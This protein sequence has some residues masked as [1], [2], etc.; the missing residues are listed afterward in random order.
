[1]SPSCEPADG[2][3][4]SLSIG[5]IAGVLPLWC[6]ARPVLTSER[7]ALVERLARLNGHPAHGATLAEQY[8]AAW[9][10]RKLVC[11]DACDQS[12][13]P[14]P[15][16]PASLKQLDPRLVGALFARVSGLD[17]PEGA[18]Q[19][20]RERATRLMTGIWLERFHPEWAQRDCGVCQQYIMDDLTGRPVQHGGEFVPRPAQSPPPCRRSPGGCPKGTPERPL[21][22]TATD[23]QVWLHDLECRTTG[24][25]PCD[26]VVIRNA[27]WIQAAESQPGG[28]PTI[29]E[30]S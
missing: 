14:R 9:L 23:R 27:V 8:A 10:C 30:E 13:Q 17:D 15:L 18:R 26:A 24:K 29:A 20:E 28:P 11:W 6:A 4:R 16:E 12:G 22:L 1:M 21:T 2:L 7:E 3:T 5:G 25:Y 19:A